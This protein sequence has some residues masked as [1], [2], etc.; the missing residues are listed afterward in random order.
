MTEEM[1]ELQAYTTN[2]SVGGPR[3]ESGRMNS[4][5]STDRSLHLDNGVEAYRPSERTVEWRPPSP[6]ATT[7]PVSAAALMDHRDERETEVMRGWS[8]VGR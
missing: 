3:T 4:Q 6:P 8:P 2:A 7:R 1:D 5:S